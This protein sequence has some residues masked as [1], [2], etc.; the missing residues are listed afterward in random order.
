[1]LKILSSEAMSDVK[2]VGEAEFWRAVD[3]DKILFYGKRG[4][5]GEVGSF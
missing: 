2:T 3:K 1:M 5:K 4:K